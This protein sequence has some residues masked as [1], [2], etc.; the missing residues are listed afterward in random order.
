MTDDIDS[1]MYSGARG[2][3]AF[4]TTMAGYTR[5]KTPRSSSRMEISVLAPGKLFDPRL[6]DCAQA[7]SRNLGPFD[8]SLFV[9]PS[10]WRGGRLRLMKIESTLRCDMITWLCYCSL[11]FQI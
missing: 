6:R 10:P 1:L 8:R 3:Y 4:P 9:R 2:R 11:R 5:E 7:G